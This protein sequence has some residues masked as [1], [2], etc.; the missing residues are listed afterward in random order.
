MNDNKL[1][2]NLILKNK[3]KKYFIFIN[4][5]KIFS[6]IFFINIE[7]DANNYQKHI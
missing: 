4:L 6:N 2:F 7:N 3:I 5:L 1:I